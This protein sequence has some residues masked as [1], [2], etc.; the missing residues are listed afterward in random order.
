MIE[1]GRVDRRGAMLA[2]LSLPVTAMAAT[3]AADAAEPLLS[4]GNQAW[5]ELGGTQARALL[6]RNGE[7]L[8]QLRTD[9]SALARLS[10][11]DFRSGRT[12]TVAG[13]LLSE[14]EVA[15]AL[16]LV[17]REGRFS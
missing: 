2:A 16:D 12:L 14:A 9:R 3:Q 6:L 17:E 8:A 10:A 5:Q 11:D 15:A 1:D 7:K 4:L 13:I